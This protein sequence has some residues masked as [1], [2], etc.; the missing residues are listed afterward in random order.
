MAR[1][2]LGVV[3]ALIG[4][5]FGLSAL[6]FA[7]G[8][9]IGAVAFAPDAPD[10]TVTGP[11]LSDFASP[12][13]AEGTGIPIVRGTMRVPCQVFWTTAIIETATTTV[14]EA[15]GGKGGGGGGSVT[16]T[17]Y[18]Y[19]VSFACS[20]CDA[21]P[22]GIT[23]VRRIWADSKL[24]FSVA[25][26]ADPAT[27]DANTARGN[28]R[29]YRGLETQLADPLIASYVGAADTPAY[30]GIGY[31]VFDNLQLAD[32]GN[33]RPFI[34]AEVV[35]GGAPTFPNFSHTVASNA[36]SLWALDVR[37]RRALIARG[38]SYAL[39]DPIYRW[40]G[41]ASA[42]VVFGKV[43]A[44]FGTDALSLSLD[45]AN[46]EV[47]L[48]HGEPGAP[49]WQRWEA[50]TGASLGHQSISAIGT[51]HPS[52]AQVTEAVVLSRP[53]HYDRR[54]RFF[55][56][57]G[58]GFSTGHFYLVRLIPQTGAATC[59]ALT[60]TSSN[61]PNN[62]QDLV[63]SE[64]R[65]WI[66]VGSSKLIL[67]SLSPLVYEAPA[68]GFNPSAT[69]MWRARG[70][71]WIPRNV[72]HATSG[73]HVFNLASR[74]FSNST[75]LGLGTWTVNWNT[76]I[77]NE[78]GQV[79]FVERTLTGVD[80]DLRD[81]AGALVKSFDDAFAMA[82]EIVS[83][84]YLPGVVFMDNGAT[85]AC[86][87]TDSIARSSYPLD[88]LVE[89][90]CARADSSVPLS[91]A[92]L[93]ADTVRGYVIARPMSVR[94]GLQPLMG[95]FAFDVLESDGAIKFV[96]R[97]GASV[98][99]LTDDDIG[100]AEG[101]ANEA[102]GPIT[103]S[104]TLESEL[105]ATLYLKFANIDL[106][107]NIGIARARRLVK[108]AV[109]TPEVEFAIGFTS[110]EANLVV[111]RL[112][113]YSWL[114]G[115]R[116][117]FSLKP[118]WRKLEPTDVVTLPDGQRVRL[119]K[120][121][122][123]P[124]GPL[125]CEAVSDDAGA[126]TSFAL[127]NAA[128][129]GTGVR[130][131][132]AGLTTGLVLDIALARDIDN[133]EGLY[134]VASGESTAWAGALFYVSLDGGIT[135]QGKS[136]TNVS[137]K[138]GLQVSGAMSATASG[139]DWDHASS[140]TVRLNNPSL[141]LSTAASLDTFYNGA[142][143]AALG[144]GEDWEIVQFFDVAA[145]ADGTFT[146]KNF[147]RGRK[148]TEW[149]IR[150]WAT[151]T[152]FAPLAIDGSVH[153]VGF[154]LASLGTLSLW[155]AVT[156]GGSLAEEMEDEETFHAISAKPLSPVEI[157]GA[158]QAL[159][160]DWQLRWTRRARKLGEWNAGADVPLDEP[161]QQFDLEIWNSG[162]TLLKRT[163]A[164]ETGTTKTYTAAQVAADFTGVPAAIGVRVYQI[165]DRLGRGYVGAAAV[166]ATFV[167]LRF[168]AS[169]KTSGIALSNGDRTAARSGSAVEWAPTDRAHTEGKWYWE[170]RCDSLGNASELYFGITKKTSF[171]AVTPS[172]GT[173]EQGIR[174]SS[175][176]GGATTGDVLI[177]AWDAT[178]GK[179][180]LGKNGTWNSGG[181]PAAGTGAGATYTPVDTD[182]WRPFCSSDNIG[183]AWTM[184]GRFETDF[185]YPVPN[186]FTHL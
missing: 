10:T 175:M 82:T 90:L 116:F 158:R 87:Y 115:E 143:A 41:T 94:Q 68:D 15:E 96:K 137:A 122:Y 89:D 127:G 103:V 88:T 14:T 104:R 119:V 151:G 29:I 81:T 19:S 162:F 123:A 109:N 16:Q 132:A 31:L 18:T 8:Y 33:H 57:S 184:T 52:L 13:G 168:S 11:R 167:P 133:D 141:A 145:N 66:V 155:K 178:T 3:G 136:V 61:G 78:H 48:F 67:A 144:D 163:F 92:S 112:M 128:E 176:P 135:W 43:S 186:G 121:E 39:D 40:D 124:N 64:G 53:L 62:E 152:R 150:A 80:A 138:L 60:A 114:E 73:W 177:L 83:M 85:A 164:A 153:R 71:I 7:I 181:D 105:P 110:A 125:R 1:L 174:A 58:E 147:L 20:I 59:V 157:A 49:G 70:E 93:A 100:A 17:S 159:S 77:E 179:L 165:S 44:A 86:F 55:W 51:S 183:V 42:P 38:G 32:F 30:R 34:E 108:S 74:T 101:A 46:D 107:Y 154:S 170:L 171:S 23:G 50:S 113:R 129:T 37:R 149:A 139:R 142:N 35:F 72:N 84:Y 130:L 169:L 97:G 134:L 22:S 180:W 146:L 27:F 63:D 111:D 45:E 156:F 2:A 166:T 106:D 120:T 9:G 161:A 25:D 131:G 21:A 47:V 118:L 98:A 28:I 91:T 76:A 148:G 56:T 99:T 24:V 117:S 12:A 65:V 69:F 95:G 6:G 79:W 36:F 173:S 182:L 140:I 26:G 4:A 5:P 172:F 75:A 160:G 54:N 126:F 102:L 185:G